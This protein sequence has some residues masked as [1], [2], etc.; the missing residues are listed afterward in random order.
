M[1]QDLALIFTD[2]NIA[3]IFAGLENLNIS[4]DQKLSIKYKYDK[5]GN[6]TEEVWSAGKDKIFRYKYQYDTDN[7]LIS[8]KEYDSENELTK[9]ITYEYGDCTVSYIPAT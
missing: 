4:E 9:A 1:M 5:K 6:L 7:N 2:Y 8:K 3:Y